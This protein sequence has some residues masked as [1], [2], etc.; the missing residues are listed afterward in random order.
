MFWNLALYFSEILKFYTLYFRWHYVASMQ[1][2]RSQL[3]VTSYA[4]KLWAIGGENLEGKLSCVEVYDPEVDEWSDAQIPMTTIE[5]AITGCTF[6]SKYCTKNL[7]L[8]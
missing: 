8:K 1:E 7:F 2:A 3:F 5:G 6:S 4:G